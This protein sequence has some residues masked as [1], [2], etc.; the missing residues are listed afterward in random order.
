MAEKMT[1]LERVVAALTFKEP[2]RIPVALYFQSGIQHDL[3]RFDYTWEEALTHPRKLFNVV[4]RQY[5]YWGADNF[6]LPCDFRV[7]G[8][9]FGSKVT[10]K[11]KA[12]AGY[13]IGV[14][15][16]WVIKGPDDLKNVKVPDP[17]K[18]GRM[19][20]ILETISMLHKKYPE[21]PIIGFVN[22]PPD[23]VTDMRQGHYQQ[24]FLDMAGNPQFLHQCLELATQCSIEFA[25]AMIKAGACAIATVEGG[26]VDQV[27]SPSQYAE[28]VAPYHAKIR[29]A[30]SPVPYVYHQCENATP[31]MDI[32]F[33]TVKPACIAFHDSVDLK[34]AKEKYGKSVALAGNV[35]VSKSGTPL[36]DGTPE[37]VME[38]ARKCI[39]IGREGG[40]FILS[41]G[42]EVHHMVPEEN[43]LA[44]T[45]AAR[46]YG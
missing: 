3:K 7:E 16:E 40:G 31:F 41:A 44:L 8:E 25:K 15:T 29:E 5:T 1:P 23:T 19:P 4:E 37:E 33:N 34:W 9:A 35:G 6:F 21:V 24:L 28:F 27:V 39:E 12:G 13:R 43:L 18:A 26:M 2:D 22:G 11:L 17:Y 38:A 32:I 45:A 36:L 30:I 42:C 46:R 14:I 20:V 10:Y